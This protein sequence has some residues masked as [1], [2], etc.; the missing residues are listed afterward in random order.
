VHDSFSRADAM[1]RESMIQRQND[2]IY[3][4]EF[5][6]LMEA[7]KRSI[8]DVEDTEDSESKDSDSDMYEFEFTS[9][10]SMD[11]DE[12]AERR[13]F[14]RAGTSEDSMDTDEEAERR[15]FI[16]EDTEP[17]EE[18]YVG[19]SQ[20]PRRLGPHGTELIDHDTFAPASEMPVSPTGWIVRRKMVRWQPTEEHL[21]QFI[22]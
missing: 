5:A 18:M 1:M 14:I 16:R 15:E 17:A 11:T 10:G 6:A 22:N 13:E 2:E 9:E 8:I 19:L 12:E 21:K 7:H 3:R 4:R 20:G